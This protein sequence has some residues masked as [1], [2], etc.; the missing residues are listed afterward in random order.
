M[1]PIG[2]PRDGFLSRVTTNGDQKG[3][4]FLFHPHTNGRFLYS[5]QREDDER[6]GLCL[7]CAHA[8]K[9]GI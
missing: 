7:W 9:S 6:M 2:D 3:R 1:M 4:T 8:T 5:L